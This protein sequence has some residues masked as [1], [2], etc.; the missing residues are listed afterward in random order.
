MR[1]ALILKV[2]L[3]FISAVSV[4]LPVQAQTKKQIKELGEKIETSPIFSKFYSG[5]ALYD[6]AV[7]TFLYEYQADKYFTPASNTKIFTLY[8]SLMVL[9]DSIPTL[10]YQETDSSLVFWGT[11]DPSFLNPL[12]PKD[13][14]VLTFLQ[15]S[16]K[17][18]FF[19]DHNFKEQAFGEGWAWDDF[20]YTYQL[21]RSPMPM[22][23]HIASFRH[24]KND[25]GFQAMPRLM[26]D[27]VTLH[28]GLSS[29]TVQFRRTNINN[30]A[31][32][33]N[34]AAL[35]G[36]PYYEELPIHYDAHLWTRLLADT[37]GKIVQKMQNNIPLADVKA[38]YGDIPAELTYQLMMQESD[39]F[40]AEQLLLVCANQL[41]G[42]QNTASAIQYALDS[43]LNGLPDKPIWVDGS[44][45]SRYNLFTP[46]TLVKLLEKVQQRLPNERLFNIF[47]QVVF[48]E[49]LKNGML[50]K[51]D[52]PL[53]CSQKQERLVTNI[54]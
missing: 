46:R 31:I 16:Q 15:Q 20:N 11:G 39:N 17:N 49:L 27:F 37:L 52:N 41:F 14:S 13:N 9:G 10:L 22:F 26:A 33:C 38:L 34:N 43:L 45:L 8:T 24:Q 30:N 35:A 53:M 18:L 28:P 23:G 36:V 50:P 3:I 42:T 4:A 7:S 2:I 29:K 6:P 40:V 48:Q 47:Q 5:F 51:E 44:G 54:V 1:N 19:S 21:E 25:L 32:E 12:L